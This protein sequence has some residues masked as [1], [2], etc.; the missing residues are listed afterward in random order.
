[1]YTS[2]T[3]QN[4]VQNKNLILSQ[5]QV[6]Y[7]KFLSLLSL[8]DRNV[9]CIYHVPYVCH[10]SCTFLSDDNTVNEQHN[11]QNPHYVIV[12]SPCNLLHHWLQIKHHVLIQFE[13]GICLSNFAIRTGFTYVQK[14]SLLHAKEEM[15]S[16]NLLKPSGYIT[17]H[18]V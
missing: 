6:R 11:L 18:Q 5:T 1:M 4:F 2:Q 15:V 16:G 9:A 3:K 10:M 14:L 12:L 8:I 13:N 17:Y 7:P